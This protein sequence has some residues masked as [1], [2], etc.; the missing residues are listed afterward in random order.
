MTSIT[1]SFVG[2]VA[3]LCCAHA[4]AAST[5]LF[6]SKDT[7]I[8]ANNVNNSAGGAP[9]MF[10]GTDDA[11]ATKRALLAFN[12]SSIP[13]GSIINNVQLTLTLAKTAGDVTTGNQ[14]ISLFK[15]GDSWDEGSAG[16][17]QTVAAS[18]QGF[19][20]SVGDATWNARSFPSPTWTTAGGDVASFSA[21]TL[22]GATVNTGYTWTNTAALDADVQG[23][24][25]NPSS[26]F[27]WL[28]VNS[29]ESNADTYRAFYTK[30]GIFQPQLQITYTAPVPEPTCLAVIALT[31][32]TLATRRRRAAQSH[33]PAQ[34]PIEA[35]T[36][37]L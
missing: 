14:T 16:L 33:Q 4:F 6:S 23:W 30:E 3:L 28:L 25:N 26:N 29:N 32:L 21:T 19:A 12:F 9:A 37:D 5:T 1:R 15:L 34:V 18:E 17:G 7:T 11:S 13:A 31:A 10:A 2:A 27:G 24:V 35:N 22:V 20:A 36:G 8:F